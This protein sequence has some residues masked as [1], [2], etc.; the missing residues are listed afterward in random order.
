MSWI[1]R[2][3]PSDVADYL[4][5]IKITLPNRIGLVQ[6]DIRPDLI[7]DFDLLEQQLAETPEML[8][9]WDMLLAEQVSKVVYLE[10]R[11][12]IIRGEALRRM[13]EDA[14]SSGIEIRRADATD[15]I[16]T[17][18]E[19]IRVEY[20]IVVE[21]RNLDRVKAVVEAIKT[22]SRHLQSLAGFK[23]EEQR[24]IRA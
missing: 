24:G 20:S 18:E 11:N 14:K 15:L 12:K 8:A 13:L 17:D 22:K 6:N 5:N 2:N 23:R 4:F 16:E 3:V 1:K 21:T 7:I 10:R 9:Y 19:V